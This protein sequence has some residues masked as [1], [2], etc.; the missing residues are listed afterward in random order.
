MR[1]ILFF[2]CLLFLGSTVVRTQNYEALNRY[3]QAYSQNWSISQGGE[4]KSKLSLLGKPMP[5]FN[6][7]KQL[8]SKILRGKFVVLDFWAT[9]CGGCRL[10]SIDL[11]SLFIRHSKDYGDV[12]LIGVDA[13]EKMTNKGFVAAD[14]WKSKNIGFPMVEG[15]AADAC[16]KSIEGGH[17]CV[18]LVDDK[19]LIRGRW[20][21][22]SPNTATEIRFAV[23][24]LH[25]VP[26]DH[27]EANAM[28]VDKLQA[29][30]LWME[31]LYLLEQMP[32]NA[33]N[34]LMKFKSLLRISE[35]KVGKLFD[36][37]KKQYAEHPDS[38][39][40]VA[41]V[42]I[43]SGTESSSLLKMGMDAIAFAINKDGSN[44][45]RTYE[46]LGWLRW[47]YGEAMKRY[48]LGTLSNAV[49]MAKQNNADASEVSR[50]TQLK[51]DCMSKT[52]KSK[53]TINDKYSNE[54]E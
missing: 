41:D 3:M 35:W 40:K 36:R 53:P 20:D 44:D 16:C 25:I 29:Q 15:K 26:R 6:F 18:V 32:Q 33:Q 38:L 46:K 9:W 43:E 27:I 8:N 23:W 1:R 21:A 34:D 50:L 52:L 24:A 12:Q 7:N 13:Y 17:P 30:G 51:D 4:D 19:G 14:F 47:Q 11:D 48:A 45:Y 28:A 39:A 22:W 54:P 37:M 42:I 5:V 2:V 49:K 31:A 10:M